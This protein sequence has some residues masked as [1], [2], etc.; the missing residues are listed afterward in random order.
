ME[1]LIVFL[2]GLGLAA[3]EMLR[4]YRGQTISL[5]P[6]PVP[7]RRGLPPVPVVPPQPT[8]LELSRVDDAVVRL[9]RG[10]FFTGAPPHLVV[11]REPAEQRLLEAKPRG[12][13]KRP[14]DLETG[15]PE[16]D[17]LLLVVGDPM[18]VAAALD[19]AARKCLLELLTWNN[20][21]CPG[22]AG[23]AQSF[24]SRRTPDEQ[25]AALLHNARHDP[26][27][28]VRLRNMELLLEHLAFD[29]AV[30]ELARQAQR[31]SDPRIR[32]LS[33]TH[34]PPGTDAATLQ[35][36]LLEL[37]RG[38]YAP[39]LRVQAIQVLAGRSADNSKLRRQL[40]GLL[41]D[42][43]EQVRS[44]ALQQL[45][46]RGWQ[47]ESGALALAADQGGELGLVEGA[48]AA[49]TRPDDEVP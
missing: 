32:L 12:W 11:V 10:A 8:W 48:A 38:S 29:P 30:I 16:L 2:A 49:V 21:R 17:R 28:G 36:L 1:L 40:I 14:R 18:Q 26:L 4:P 37:A 24:S 35:M 47:P 45:T 15:D 34:P 39:G 6:K 33:A 44:A 5:E 13:E 9:R 25:R 22:L 31:D 41:Q 46:A 42:E 3:F 27:P 7:V 43:N 19:P 20:D 23:L